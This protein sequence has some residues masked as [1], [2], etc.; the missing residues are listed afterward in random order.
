MLSTLKALTV[1]LAWHAWDLAAHR[2]GAQP[3]WMPSQ[4]AHCHRVS[5]VQAPGQVLPSHPQDLLAKSKNC[6]DITGESW[7][8]AGHCCRPHAKGTEFWQ[9]EHFNAAMPQC[10]EDTVLSSISWEQP[11]WFQSLL[12]RSHMR[13]LWKWKFWSSRLEVAL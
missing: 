5:R 7:S 11:H 4:A 3:C 10:L 13:G 1:I 12:C 8:Y 6:S 2:R 9:Q